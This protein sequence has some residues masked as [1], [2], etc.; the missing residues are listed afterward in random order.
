M[1]KQEYIERKERIGYKP[2]PSDL[3]DKEWKIVE[4]LI[5]EKKDDGRDDLYPKRDILNA[6]FYKLKNGCAW[7][8]L[9]HDFPNW[10]SVYGYFQTWQETE[11]I[12]KIRK[13]LVKEERV[14][15]GKNETPTAAVIDSKSVQTTE[16][17]GLK[18]SMQTK[19]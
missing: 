14:R 10:T 7:R 9:P 4:P 5:P 13:Q 11:I 18:V 16:K 15:L 12:R 3:S 8:S 1:K 2:Y 19:R 6:I 17:G